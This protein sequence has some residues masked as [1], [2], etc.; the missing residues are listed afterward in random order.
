MNTTLS[1]TGR[2]G[3][4]IAVVAMALA[5][6]TDIE[7]ALNRGG[8]TPCSEYIKQDQDTKRTTITKFLEQQSQN[9]HEPA[10]TVV[11]ATMVSVELLCGAQA[12]ADTPVKNADV[13]GI[14]LR[15]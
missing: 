15:K 2:T 11:D 3:L 7:R 6:C 12:N 10:G 4:G 5:G 9:D 8:D 1:R 13:A 14:F